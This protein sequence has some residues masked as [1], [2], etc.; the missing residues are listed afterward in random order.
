LKAKIFLKG[1]FFVA[2]V[3]GKYYIKEV[4]SRRIR[5]GLTI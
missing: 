3:K 4:G 2:F 1:Y 5:E